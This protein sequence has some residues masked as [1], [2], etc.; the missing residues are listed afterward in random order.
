LSL[1]T[2]S[3]VVSGIRHASITQGN[4]GKNGGSVRSGHAL[5]FRVDDRSVQIKLP[6]IPDVQD[7]ETVTL[8]GRIKKGTFQALAMRNDRTH[9]VYATP[10]M[11]G[12]IMGGL[13]TAVG[14]PLL[15]VFVGIFFIGFGGYTLYQA[16]NYA[17]A[18]KLLQA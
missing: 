14:I 16:Y 5:A 9:A 4:I 3:G 7:G 12:Y 1:T 8:A 13:M 2:L 10:A 11:P 17:Q 18:A 15:F 6:E